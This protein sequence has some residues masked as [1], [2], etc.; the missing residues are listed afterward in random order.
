MVE[1]YGGNSQISQLVMK[2]VVCIHEPKLGSFHLL[3]NKTRYDAKGSLDIKFWNSGNH[4]K[5]KDRRG[6]KVKLRHIFFSQNNPYPVSSRRN[7]LDMENL[8]I[9]PWPLVN[10]HSD[11]RLLMK[12]QNLMGRPHRRENLFIM[13]RMLARFINI[14]II[15]CRKTNGLLW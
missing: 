8:W 14:S 2:K 1:K 9:Q 15:I 12:I 7:N 4:V 13:L 5:N 11:P 6:Q 10:Y 3:P